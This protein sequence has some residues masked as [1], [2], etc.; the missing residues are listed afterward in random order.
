M[1]VLVLGGTRFF[2]R[3]IV[4]ELV[5]AGHEVVA[6]TRGQTPVELPP[7][8]AHVALDRADR[9]AFE[10]WLAGERFDAIVDNIAYDADDVRS[11]VRAAGGRLAHYL[12]TST[13][14]VYHQPF[15][16]HPVREEEADLGYRGD[17]A[18]GEGKRRAELVLREEAGDAFPWTA[19]ARASSS[20]RATTRCASGGRP[21]ACSTAGRSCC[22]PRRRTP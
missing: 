8:V 17:G 14:S 5:N 20:A 22:R 18:Y 19:S 6:A 9:A 12:L 3:L 21:S 16:R 1:R 11:V 15:P 7:S 4:G 13:G 2:G 10:G